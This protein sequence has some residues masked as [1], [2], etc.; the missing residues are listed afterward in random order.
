MRASSGKRADAVACASLAVLASGGLD[1]AVLL[2]ESAL[3][4][5]PVAPI[6]VRAGLVWERDELLALRRFVAALG[7]PEVLP[8]RV[9][10]LPMADLLD[11]HWSVTGRAVPGWNAPLASNYIP[12]RNLTLLAK[13]SLLCV[14]S[15]ITELAMA[16]LKANPFPDARPRFLLAF[17]RALLAA[18][19]FHLRLLTPYRSLDKAAVIRRG[20]HLP[21]GLTLSCARPR[22]LVH[23]GRCTKCAERSQAFKNAGVADPTRYRCR[24]P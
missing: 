15:G 22:G 7:R 24:L 1:S 5:R 2:G 6:Y 19:G 17:E 11:G 10:A 9:L 12:G 4:G 13:A 23:C 3:S 18:T 21:L 8:L 14:Q 20:R 16:Q